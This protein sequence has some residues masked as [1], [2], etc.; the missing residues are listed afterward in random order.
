[1]AENEFPPHCC[2]VHGVSIISID[3][4]YYIRNIE[5]KKQL[6]NLDNRI[7]IPVRVVIAIFVNQIN[8]LPV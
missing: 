4:S 7:V 3:I 1:M 2:G 8:V 6:F 5:Q